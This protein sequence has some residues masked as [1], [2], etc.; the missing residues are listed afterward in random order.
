MILHL[1]KC[2]TATYAKPISRQAWSFSCPSDKAHLWPY[3]WRGGWAAQRS[4]RSGVVGENDR[5]QLLLTVDADGVDV[6]LDRFRLCAEA[7]GNEHRVNKVSREKANLP[8]TK[9]DFHAAVGP[10]LRPAAITP[11]TNSGVLSF[12]VAQMLTSGESGMGHA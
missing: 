5:A 12:P 7:A 11:M 2:K 1:E 4:S 9:P 10:L 6:K 3:K 8:T